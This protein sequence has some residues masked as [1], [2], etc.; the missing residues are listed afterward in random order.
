V[1]ATLGVRRDGAIIGGFGQ[2]LLPEERW[3]LAVFRGS[4][5]FVAS[6]ASGSSMELVFVLVY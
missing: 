4:D 3:F 5:C 1:G 6:L 2:W